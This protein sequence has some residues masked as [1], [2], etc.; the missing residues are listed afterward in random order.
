MNKEIVKYC[1]EKPLIKT[2]SGRNLKLV[3]MFEYS[4]RDA[5][6]PRKQGGSCPLAY[7]LKGL[8]GL[9]LNQVQKAVFWR[10]TLDKLKTIISSEI[11]PKNEFEDYSIDELPQFIL[12]LPS[13]FDVNKDFF[14]TICRAL[15][16]ES[17][18]NEQCIFNKL[19]EMKNIAVDKRD[20]IKPLELN[21]DYQFHNFKNATVWIL[22]DL[23]ASGA[24]LINAYDLLSSIGVKNVVAF[25]LFSRKTL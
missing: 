1:Y 20:N 9:S 16:F 4:D 8:D 22:D 23:T 12:T 14:K 15:G 24:T 7:A 11:L 6:L 18:T 5:N 2:F 17:T 10:Q 25:T 19:K 21:Q 13:S 3:S